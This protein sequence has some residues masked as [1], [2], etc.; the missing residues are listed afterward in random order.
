M[1]VPEVTKQENG[2][3]AQT[4]VNVQ[5]IENKKFF[6]KNGYLKS[7]SDSLEIV[8]FKKYNENSY[9]QLFHNL[10]SL[11]KKVVAK[12]MKKDEDKTF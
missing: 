10:N 5:I 7:D 2:W 11:I 9:I 6:K 12:L 4:V 3:Q 8:V 1:T